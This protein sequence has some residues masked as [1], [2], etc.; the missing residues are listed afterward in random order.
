MI[1]LLVPPG[2]L[3]VLCLGA[4]PDDIEI[5]C[6]ATLLSLAH[7]PETE[8]HGVVMS[9]TSERAKEARAALPRFVPGA[10]V[11]V[12]NLPD[13]RLP[14]H[15]NE[16][17]EV[18]EDVCRRRNPQLV[19]AP[20]SDDAHQDHRLLGS[21]VTTV[22]R[23]ALVLHY[24]I[25]KWDGDLGPMTHYVTATPEAARRKVELLDLSYPSQ[26]NR[27]WWDSE[28]FLGLLRLRG[29]E[30]RAPYAEAFSCAKAVVDLVQEA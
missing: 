8:V 1:G 27:N 7:R 13:G 28:V 22:W 12:H 25:P 17:K 2:P 10:D 16:V 21:M 14:A 5:G 24:E 19:L 23:D 3:E 20:R 6:G 29:V 30:A 9:A 4:H 18:L 15:W 11:E 26:R